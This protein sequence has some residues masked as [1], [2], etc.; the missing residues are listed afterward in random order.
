GRLNEEAKTLGFD[1]RYY[2]VGLWSHEGHLPFG[3]NQ[4]GAGSSFLSQN[5]RVTN[6]W[7]FENPHAKTLAKDIFFP[8]SII[9]LPVTSVEKWACAN[10]ISTVDFIK[11]NIQGA[12]LE[13]LRGCGP[14][15]DSALG[16]LVEV[17]FVESYV[18]RPMFSD[19]DPYL[20]KRGFTFFD[21]LAHHYVGRSASTVETQ[22]LPGLATGFG[23]LVS[24]WGQLIEAH[25]L[26]LRDPIGSEE[27]TAAPATL[28]PDRCV[29]LI[30]VAE[31]YGQVEYALELTRWLVDRRAAGGD[32]LEAEHLKAIEEA[33]AGDY[34]RYYHSAKGDAPGADLI[35]KALA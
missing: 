1:C 8:V 14:I 26:Y 31:T 15:L 3:V 32:H 10:G 25:A 2:P 30:C 6:R 24:S 20:R 23:Q 21:L 17:A 13:V 4:T 7:K 34:R 22:H 9:E 5:L 16:L 33:A 19:I 18:G 28:S 27:P 12:E 29:K 35:P 11:L